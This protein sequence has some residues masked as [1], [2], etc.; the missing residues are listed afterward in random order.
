MKKTYEAP[1]AEKITFNYRDQVVAASGDDTP[2]RL[3]ATVT[4]QYWHGSN[5]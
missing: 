4:E 1:M 3:I 5:D 2:P